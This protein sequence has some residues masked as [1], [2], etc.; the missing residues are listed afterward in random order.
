[1]KLKKLRDLIKS[2]EYFKLYQAGSFLFRGTWADILE[3]YANYYVTGIGYEN[4]HDPGFQ[5]IC[6]HVLPPEGV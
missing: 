2:D 5:F 3:N 1:M 6:F 4:Y